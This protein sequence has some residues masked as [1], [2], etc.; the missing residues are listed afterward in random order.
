VTVDETDIANVD[1]GQAVDITMDAYPGIPFEGKVMRIDPQALVESNVTNIHVRVELDNSDVKFKL[2]KPGMN[3][4]CEFVKDKKDNVL[5]VPSEAVRTDDQGRYVE[6]AVGGK[7]AP[8]DPKTNTPADPN[9]LIDVKVVKRRVELG[10]EGNEAD[11][12]TGGLK[13]GDTIITQ[14]IQ[15]IVQQAGGAIGG[16]FGMRPGG[17]RGR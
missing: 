12:I 16:G 3:A 13:E 11:E 7:P 15:P 9:T 1:V 2:L 4:T 6:V 14:T 5:S 10:L 8:G 17:G